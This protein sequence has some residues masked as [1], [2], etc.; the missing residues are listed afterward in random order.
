MSASNHIPKSPQGSSRPI[1]GSQD[2]K[3]IDSPD[4]T[5]LLREVV[6]N[7]K[8]PNSIKSSSHSSTANQQSQK[9]EGHSSKKS[10]PN[11][12]VENKEIETIKELSDILQESHQLTPLSLTQQLLP[13]LGDHILSVNAQQDIQKIL[14]IFVHQIG[15]VR[16]DLGLTIQNRNGVIHV[17][18]DPRRDDTLRQLLTAY[19]DDL[20]EYLID[21]GHEVSISI[22]NGNSDSQSQQHQPYEEFHQ[23]EDDEDEDEDIFSISHQK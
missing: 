19:Q 1:P 16:I 2:D 4:F 12:A 3:P 7:Y 10:N 21:K 9:E 13:S 6:S 23:E 20:K 18:I 15:N 22:T 17:E 5:D 14:S 8:H 11:L